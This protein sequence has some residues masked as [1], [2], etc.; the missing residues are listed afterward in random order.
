VID[1]QLCDDA[2]VAGM[3]GVDEALGVFERAVFG[4]DG[5]VF[6]DVVAVVL[7]R[8]RVEI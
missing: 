6:G 5:D 1:D 8:R 3:G 7:A 2:D 4:M